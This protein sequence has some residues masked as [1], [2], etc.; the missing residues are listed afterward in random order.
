MNKV[1]SL[2]NICYYVDILKHDMGTPA[3]ANCGSVKPC[4][5]AAAQVINTRGQREI[6][7]ACGV[8]VVGH[9]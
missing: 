3:R 7:N 1:S 2:H 9:R 6:E 8:E 4:D 5:V